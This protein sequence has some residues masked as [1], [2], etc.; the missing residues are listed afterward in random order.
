[1]KKNLLNKETAS[2]VINRV[3]HLS[4]NAKPK[5]GIMNATEMLMH[6]NLCNQQILEEERSM[7]KTNAKQFLLRIIAL[8]LAPNFTKNLK[9]EAK[10]D[11]KGRIDSTYFD[12]EKDMFI[13]IIKQ[14]PKVKNELTLTHPAFGNISTNEWG[15]AAYKHMDHHLRQFGV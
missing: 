2:A 6:C 5:W 7:N 12:Q 15:I 4:V 14:F 11:T 13:S 1:M 10:N 9:S 3:Q 8:Y